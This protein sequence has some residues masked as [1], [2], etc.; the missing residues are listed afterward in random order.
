MINLY[1]LIYLNFHS[2][3]RI[4]RKV[5]YALQSSLY[6]IAPRLEKCP[7]FPNAAAMK[8]FPF[9]RGMFSA[10]MH[11]WKMQLALRNP[12]ARLRRSP[13][14]IQWMNAHRLDVAQPRARVYVTCGSAIPNNDLQRGGKPQAALPAPWKRFARFNETRRVRVRCLER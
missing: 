12:V 11:R 5:R 10:A 14:N 7:S 8:L 4:T 13:C 6:A 2:Y 9:P 1:H 3:E